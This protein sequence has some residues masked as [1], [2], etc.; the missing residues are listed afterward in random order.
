MVYALVI[1][2]AFV[3]AFGSVRLFRFWRSLR[4]NGRHEGRSLAAGGGLVAS[5]L[6]ETTHVFY[7]TVLRWRLIGIRW[8]GNTPDFC[9]RAVF[10]ERRETGHAF[11]SVLKSLEK[12]GFAPLVIRAD[13]CAQGIEASMAIA[14]LSHFSSPVKRAALLAVFAFVLLLIPS[15]P[16][17]AGPTPCSSAGGTTTCQQDQSAG[18][19]ALGGDTTLTV[20][21]LNHN[22]TPGG[23]IAGAALSIAPGPAG[24]GPDSF[25]GIPSSNATNGSSSPDVAINVTS[26]GAGFTIITG[27]VGIDANSSGQAGGNGGKGFG[28]TLPCPI[29]PLFVCPF[30]GIGGNGGSGGNGGT[31][32]V[33]TIGAG[34]ITTTGDNNHGVLALS[35]GGAG[36]QGGDSVSFLGLVGV[37]GNGGSGGAPNSVT[38]QNVFDI[39]T[40]GAGAAGIWAQSVGGGG[41][42]GG[43]EG[44]SAFNFGGHGAAASNGGQVQ[45]TN[46]SAIVTTGPN[47]VG[48]FAQ[49]VG[50]FAGSG[51]GAYGLFSFGGS[52]SS[53]GAGGPVTVTTTGG[54]IET[55]GQG[56]TAIFAQS[57]GGGGGAGGAGGGLIGFGGSGS[58]GGAGGLVNVQNAATLTVHGDLSSGIFAQ[59]VGGG[60]GTGGIG[61]GVGLVAIGGGGGTGGDGGTVSVTNTADITLSGNGSL[62]P[63]NG[64][65]TDAAGIYAQSVGGG[66]GNGGLAVGVLSI[67]TVGGSGGEAGIGQ[68]VFVQNSGDIIHTSCANCV[69]APDIF[70]QSVG[71]GGGDGGKSI[72]VLGLVA[73]GGNGSGGGIGNTVTVNNNG[74][75]TAYGDMS[76]GLFAQSVGGGGG[77]GGFSVAAGLFATAAVGGNGGSGGNGGEVCVNANAACNGVLGGLAPVQIETHGFRSPGIFAQSVG[78]GGGTGGSAVSASVGIWGSA[79][80]GIGGRGGS[81]G[82]GGTVFV[83]SD[84]VITTS[85]AYS[86]GVE[87]S[88]VGGG[89]GNGGYAIAATGG[90]TY[91]SLALSFGGTGG[92]GNIGGA[93]TVV[94]TTNVSTDGAFSSAVEGQSIGGGGGS[95]GFTVGVAGSAGAGLA[96]TFGGS[97]GAGAN[98][99]VVNV[100]STG[101]L[102]TGHPGGGVADAN[103]NGIFAES[104][105]GSGGAGG[106]A[107]SAAGGVY[108]AL[109]LGLGGSGGNGGD[110]KAVTANN[111]SLATLGNQIITY[112][113]LSN[114]IFAQSVGGSG[115]S[116]GFAI[117]AAGAGYGAIGLSFGGGAGSGGNGDSVTVTSFGAIT[118]YGIKSN[119]IFAQSLGGGGGDGGFAISA[120]GAQYGALSLAMG[121]AGANGGQANSV[122]VTSQGAITTHGDQSN[123]IFAQSLGGGGGNGGF[124]ISGTL[125]TSET[126]ANATLAIGGKGGAGATGGAVQVVSTGAIS[127]AGLASD[128]ILAQSIGGSGGNGGFSGALQLGNGGVAGAYS[129]G[130]AGGTCTLGVCNSG[131]AVGVTS[132][133]DITTLQANSTGIFAQSVGGG[134]GNGGFSLLV[135]ATYNST[136]SPITPKTVG[137]SGGVGGTGGNVTVNSTGVVW[138]TG[139]L[140]DGIL[141]QSIGGGGGHG[142]FSIGASLS[143]DGATDIN[144]IGGAGGSGNT[145]GQVSVTAVASASSLKPGY[146][147]YTT[148]DG[149]VGIF[150]QSVGGGGGAG[151]FSVAGSLSVNDGAKANSIGGAGGTGGDSTNV[152]AAGLPGYVPAVQVGNTGSIYT[153]GLNSSGILAQ[154]IGGGGG[155]GAFSIAG[156]VSLSGGAAQSQTVGGTGGAAGKGGDVV[157][158]NNYVNNSASSITTKG[159]LSYGILAQSVGGGGGNGGFAI[160]GAVS[161]DK[162]VSS[163]AVGGA[164]GPGNSAGL[165]TVDSGGIIT[166]GS[167]VFVNSV[168]NHATSGA[169]SVGILAQSIGGG[170]GNG[171]FSGALSVSTGGKAAS[172]TVGGGGGIGSFGNTVIVDTKVGSQIFTF[173]DNASGILAQSVGGGGGNGGFTIGASFTNGSDADGSTDAV[174][175]SGAGG[176]KG[177]DVTVTNRGTITTFGLL[178][179]GIIAQSIGGG[180]GNGG[181]AI[182]GSLS[183]GG[184]ATTNATGGTGGSGEGAGT[185]TVNNSG[186]ISV[187]AAGTIGILAQSVGG[188]GGTGG[189]AGGLSFSTGG[190][191]ATNT[192]GGSGGGGGDGGLVNVNNSAAITANGDQG[193]GILAQSVGGKGGNG[194]F[195]VTAAGSTQADAETNSVGGS[196]GTAGNA[197]KVTVA[198][199]LGGTITT[200]GAMAYGII[201]QSIGGGGG[202][203]GF[204]VGGSLGLG[205]DA[206]STIGGGGGAGGGFGF[207]VRVDNYDTITTKGVASTGIL[208]QSVGGGGGAGG[209]AG[210]LSFSSNGEV[211][212]T[213]G[214][215]N[216]GLGNKASDVTVT[217][218]LGAVVQTNQANSIGILA[219]A[220]G[221][222]GGQSGFS[223]SGGVSGS[224]DGMVQ[225]IGGTGGAGGSTAGT[226]VTVNNDGKIITNGA[227]SIGIFA[228]SVGGGGGVGGVSVAGSYGSSNGAGA[229]VGG[230]G[231]GGGGAAGDVKVNNTGSIVVNGSGSVGVY[232]Q[233]VG[234]GG[235]AAGFAGAFNFSGGGTLSNK[236]GGGGAGGAG[237]NVTVISTGSIRT[238]SADSIGVMAQSIGGGGGSSVFSIAQQTNSLTESFMSIGGGGA[239][240]Q[241]ANGTVI[242]QVSGGT[243]QTQGDLSYGLLAQAIGAGGGAAALS[244]PDP[245]TIGAGGNV[246]SLGA[247][248]TI[249]GNGNPLNAQNSNSTTT[250]GA[251][252]IGYAAQSIGGGGGSGGVTGDVAFTATGPLSLALGGST[253][254]GGAGGALALTN[255]ATYIHTGNGPAAL[256]ASGDAA[257]GLLGQAI[258]GGGGIGID[259]LG[260]VTGTAGLASLTLGG[261]EGAVVDADTGGALTLISGG[262]IT[263]GGR[264]A[265]GVVAQTIGG[266]GGFAALTASSGLSATGVQFQ[267]GAVGGVGGAA[268]PSQSS[269]WTL[270]SGDIVTTGKLSDGFVA[271]A[272]GGGGGLAG[273]VSD[274]A[275][276]PQL[277]GAA[278]GALAGSGAGSLVIVQ[279]QSTIATGGAGAIGLIAQ[280]IGGGG[281]AAQAYGVSGSG[282]VTL[283]GSG[284]ASGAGAAV[285]VTSQAAITTGGAA[286]HALVAQSIGGGGG[287]FQAFDA[288]GALLSTQVQAAAGGG[289]GNGGAVNVQVQADIVTTGA[290]A[291]GVI[292]QSIAGGGG[293]VGGGVLFTTLPT[294]GSFAGSAG[295][296]GVAG[297]VIVNAQA[298]V[299]ASGADAIAVYAESIGQTGLGA[300]IN[301]TLGNAATGTAQSVSGGTGAGHAVS[302][303][304]GAANLLTSYATLTTQGGLAGLT[305]TGGAGG[306]SVVSFGHLIG[307]LDLGGGA[308]ALDNKPYRSA[309]NPTPYSG[310]FDAGATVNLG[311]GNLFTNEGA[312]SIGALLNVATTNE[313]GNFIQTATG[314]CGAFGAPTSACGVMA[315]DLEFNNQTADRLNATGTANLGGAVVVNI[316]NPGLAL[317]G[318]HD[319]TLISAAGGATLTSPVLLSQPT[320]VATYSLVQPDPNDID[321]HYVID[322]SPSGLTQNQHAVGTTI[323]AIQTARTSPAFVQIAAALF[324]QPDVPTLG[325]VYDSLSGEGVAGSQ[326]AAFAATERFQDS[327]MQQTSFWV[328]GMESLDSNSSVYGSGPRARSWRV[329]GLGFGG[330]SNNPGNA[331]VGSAQS[332]ESGAGFALGADYQIDPA[333]LIGFAGAYGRSSYRVADRST[334][335]S[336]ENGHFAIYG[337]LRGGNIY[338][339][340]LFGGDFFGSNEKRAAAIPGTVLPSLFGTSI[341]AIP[342]FSETPTASFASAAWSGQVETGYRVALKELDVTP[343]TGAQFS[344]LHIDGFT[345]TNAGA[346]S[347]IGLSYAAQNVAS[348]P[349]FVGV[350]LSKTLDL[351][352][353]RMA[354]W[355][356]AAWRHELDPARPITASFIS[357]P[358]FSFTVNGAAAISDMARI[359]AGVKLQLANNVEAFGVFQ[360]DLAPSGRNLTGSGGIRIGW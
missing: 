182:G 32:N 211:N 50:G 132:V 83:A 257:V 303:A 17:W 356:R 19:A 118:T 231:G 233:S 38:V 126:A 279:S 339:T 142:G 154:S 4:G 85:G 91:A 345:E 57:I 103:S 40:S 190:G 11:S 167:A 323:N 107:V 355:L 18:A 253:T 207:V 42:S 232:A 196:G 322:F 192:V 287:L 93:V 295:A 184:G 298:N 338:L 15:S 29:P 144:A 189:F 146:T 278:L 113:D 307:S 334:A 188:G 271:Q 305:V 33:T 349:L 70:A 74:N 354:V 62:N 152:N 300:A 9:R 137:G 212:N 237:G 274:G 227:N 317:P 185:V 239:G 165:V 127:T 119:G 193:V 223:I 147:A 100:S 26:P 169:G 288:S 220:I 235:G 195:A 264:F 123:G 205:G 197:N 321:L 67:A 243:T 174:G 45:V 319:V 203:G 293:L 309:A 135:Q 79:S 267:L 283:G 304:G 22:I 156:S 330:A 201:A 206:K 176:G 12:N 357:A 194:G 106:F 41:G 273:F 326:Q 110:G 97:G 134:G 78:G 72:S 256:V 102:V 301:V 198:N 251:G 114:G 162:D 150:A 51:G 213:V 290:G 2:G 86:P 314:S 311:A 88:S 331:Y 105:G 228:Q 120:A 348:A 247:T 71:G 186:A 171:G 133:G 158:T 157:V 261:S 325:K 98:G 191:A 294:A 234:G 178:S 143:Y 168:F 104:V 258:G 136:V 219:Q 149:S 7:G 160:S 328:N 216:G 20:N 52:P 199:T 360:G 284:G 286:A 108:G 68:T 292:A 1:R 37:A 285:N 73:V 277:K 90:P 155:N 222:G 96:L 242:V 82:T 262:E 221:G 306:D 230:S 81:G 116:G 241:G 55:H 263:T 36:G 94:S 125:T 148:G 299:T 159:D 238:V 27:A 341:P 316:L 92:G 259:A 225:S 281:G 56:S 47:A 344:L 179:D 254:G 275:Q 80:I 76:A 124:A 204:S 173:G 99:G 202:N 44:G 276:A 138:T 77:N 183:T 353:L 244:V 255:T 34:T 351:D 101:N 58:N 139:A 318:T 335:G 268:D 140:S 272:I 265:P 151:G 112:G 39:N 181:F 13:G 209:F 59:S 31:V 69:D 210:G 60:G 128:G 172:N 46:S 6:V 332:T 65:S 177:G 170:G 187:N 121:G 61:V 313:T 359:N 166:T 63:T 297:T 28:A 252:S 5:L 350:Q 215:G 8:R 115:G 35:V 240:T 54:S 320:A 236:V 246:V 16:S 23:G 89:G 302:L 64:Q 358:G 164:G 25:S 180:G 75:L 141:A 337:A 130:G 48:I 14:Q 269:T 245:L 153:G 270:K 266:G 352:T 347:V 343:Y 280:S 53:A 117:G 95:G 289:G 109:S 291:H 24:N 163:N 111:N 214:G 208:A 327:V 30:P 296:A 336:V 260:V 324:Y 3:A 217:N 66:G 161:L 10:A 122:N 308:N 175:G 200:N 43:S 84:G 21:S 249:S 229:Q 87:G 49:S 340:G 218:H 312:L 226:T 129:V 310:L 250:F 131:G 315:T 346:P 224:G 282:P 342:G 329:W 145:A 333:A 248:G